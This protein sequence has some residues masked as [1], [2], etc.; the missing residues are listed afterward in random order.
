VCLPAFF[1]LL[2]DEVLL[3]V[4]ESED[5]ELS[6]PEFE[7]VLLLLSLLDE[8]VKEELVD[9]SPSLPLP[10]SSFWLFGTLRVLTFLRLS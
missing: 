1:V 9:E 6:L 2:D 8:L 4:S 3:D 7:L 5:E 10:T